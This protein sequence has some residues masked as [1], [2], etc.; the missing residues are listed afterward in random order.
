MESLRSQ[1]DLLSTIR[2]KSISYN[3]L[4]KSRDRSLKYSTKPTQTTI[5]QK[6]NF[7]IGAAK[8]KTYMRPCGQSINK[9]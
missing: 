6:C 9:I 7:G 2:T 3:I 5:K 1:W 4:D 8:E